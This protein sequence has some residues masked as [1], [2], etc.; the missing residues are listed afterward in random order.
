MNST[1]KSAA[2]LQSM[3]IVRMRSD[4]LR[5]PAR[6]HVFARTEWAPCAGTY[7]LRQML[8]FP[9]AVKDNVGPQHVPVYSNEAY[10]VVPNQF[11]RVDRPDILE[12]LPSVLNRRILEA[13][14]M[15]ESGRQNRFALG[16]HC[17]SHILWTCRS[18]AFRS[19]SRALVRAKPRLKSEGLSERPAFQVAVHQHRDLRRAD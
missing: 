8:A 3:V 4:S 15:R 6:N 5:R 10:D 11:Q 19:D 7:D 17:R 13:L 1:P 18:A 9:A 16:D 14:R 2:C 12:R